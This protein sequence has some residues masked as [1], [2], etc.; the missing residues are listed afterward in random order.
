MGPAH[1]QRREHPH[2][3]HPLTHIIQGRK[4][5]SAHGLRRHSASMAIGRVWRIKHTRCAPW[6]LVAVQDRCLLERGAIDRFKRL[7]AALD[8]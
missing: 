7:K 8:T 4:L 5:H 2:S 3:P 6:G 1:D